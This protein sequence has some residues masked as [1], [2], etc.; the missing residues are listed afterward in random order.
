V[1]TVFQ[2]YDQTL[3][4][5]VYDFTEA[6]LVKMIE[7]AR[8]DG[9]LKS[10]DRAAHLCTTLAEYKSG[11]VMIAWNSGEPITARIE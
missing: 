7:E 10:I 5:N 6:R 9:S 8:L 3:P 2:R 1:K 4:V 11:L